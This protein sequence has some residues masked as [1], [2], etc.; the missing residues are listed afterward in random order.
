MK[1]CITL[2][3]LIFANCAF[4]QFGYFEWVN[5]SNALRERIEISSSHHL[6]EVK[7]G[8]WQVIGKLDIDTTIFKDLPPNN[9]I[10]YFYINKGRDIWFTVAGTGMVYQFTPAT[11]SF[12]RIDHTFYRG[13]NFGA[14]QF[15]R[16]NKLYSLGGEGFWAQSRVLTYYDQEKK[17]WEIVRTEN[18][19]P[20]A[21]NCGYNGYSA[22]ADLIFSAAP[23]IT[24]Y[25]IKMKKRYDD[26]L[27]A[28]D[29]K[30]LR[31]KLLGVI[32]PI[33][34]FKTN[35]DIYWDGTHFFHFFLDELY[36]IDPLANTIQLV[37]DKTQTYVVTEDANKFF[38]KGDTIYIYKENGLSVFKF[39]KQDLLK[40]A[41]YV[42]PFYREETLF[43]S[44]IVIGF[45]IAIAVGGLWFFYKKRK[46]RVRSYF[47]AD[48]EEAELK[49]IQSLIVLGNNGYLTNNDISD[50]LGI[51]EKS[52][53]NQRKIKMNII[54][55]IN[56]KIA[57]RYHIKDAISRKSISED[58]RLKAYYMKPEVVALLKK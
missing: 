31:W 9:A 33:L 43:T 1:W 46:Q 16:K 21:I 30:N 28:F 36:L 32:N 55:D 49:L 19:G 3:F 27:F 7:T 23:A 18:L 34:P 24:P 17:E 47:S 8:I 11:K 22:K 15:V 45:L 56:T 29:F 57:M 53:D 26:R 44:N 50:V 13:H 14:L 5:P 39:S 25:F 58:K 4:A 52:Q 2:L 35:W 51:N 6:K 12:V 38:N 48:F 40:K 20:E 41:K 54:N 37:E 42:G 10:K